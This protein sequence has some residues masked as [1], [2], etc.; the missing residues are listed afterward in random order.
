MAILGIHVSFRGVLPGWFTTLQPGA[1]KS[2]WCSCTITAGILVDSAV[3]N[4][5][6]KGL[7]GLEGEDGFS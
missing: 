6:Y 3:E 4:C 2:I 7:A 5:R 1:C